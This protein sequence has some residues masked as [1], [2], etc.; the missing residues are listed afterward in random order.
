VCDV[1]LWQQDEGVNLSKAPE[2]EA[3][4]RTHPLVDQLRFTRSEFMRGIKGVSDED[5]RRRVKPMNS[6]SWNVGHLAMQEQRYFLWRAQGLK[7]FPQIATEFATGAPATTPPLEQVMEA[8]RAITKQADEWLDK[9]TSK[10]LLEYAVSRG[11]PTEIMFGNLLQRTIYHYWYHNGENQAIR[12]ALG[13]T[14]LQQFVGD[15]DG[16]APYRP[17]RG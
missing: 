4:A 12:Q 14:D 3:M 9:Q 17:D 10:S 1:H 13:H 6:I 5:A 8:W 16:K 7:P 2:E 15:I 11:K